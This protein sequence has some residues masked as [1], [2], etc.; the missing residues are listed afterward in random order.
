M[1]ASGS[2][3]TQ[4]ERAAGVTEQNKR[5]LESA[6]K[7]SKGEKPQASENL[8]EEEEEDEKE[9][10]RTKENADK[11]TKGTKR[12]AED[13]D[14]DAWSPQGGTVDDTNAQSTTRGI[15]ESAGAASGTK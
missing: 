15:H 1:G 10:A 2:G 5:D 12:K 9:L 6:V 4:A 14:I 11:N 8:E 7:Q 13:N 3:L